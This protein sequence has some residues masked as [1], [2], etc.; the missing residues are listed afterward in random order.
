MNTRTTLYTSE[1]EKKLEESF[2]FSIIHSFLLCSSEKV[3]HFTKNYI[4]DTKL[5]IYLLWICLH[6]ISAHLYVRYCTP[7]G[8]VG[9]IYSIFI[10]P[11]PICYALSWAIHHGNQSIF[12][13]WC[14]F[15]AI[16][17]GHISLPKVESKMSTKYTNING[18]LNE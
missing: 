4:V 18:G 5:W 14:L 13:M 1:H 2:K 17:V 6:Y 3:I 11:T 8:V 9:F 12:N 15:G 10:G 16:C 7:I